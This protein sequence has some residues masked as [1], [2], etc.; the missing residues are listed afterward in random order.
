MYG[1]HNHTGKM[2]KGGSHIKSKKGKDGM[3]GPSHKTGGPTVGEGLAHGYN[4]GDEYDGGGYGD[5]PASE[6]NVSSED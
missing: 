4:P 3:K 2:H 1:G 5:C 6:N